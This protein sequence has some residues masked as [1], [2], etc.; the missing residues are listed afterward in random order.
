MLKNISVLLQV[1]SPMYHLCFDLFS[2]KKKNNFYYKSKHGHYDTDQGS[3][4]SPIN[5]NWLEARQEI[6]ARLYWG[7]C[8][9]SGEQEQTTGGLACLLTE[10]RWACSLHGVRVGV[11]PGVGP[12]GWL[13]CFAHPLGAV[14]CRGHAQYPA[15]APDTLI[16]LQ[17]L[18][19]WQL[20][21]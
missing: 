19:K 14:V 5:R 7:P 1:F 6:G 4:S 2:L 9:S 17:A 13:K 3:W 21:F 20:G 11:C 18:Q 8:C 15:F 16:L 12:E 10:G